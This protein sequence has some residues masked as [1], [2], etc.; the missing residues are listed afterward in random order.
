MKM[1]SRKPKAK[2][3]AS[4]KTKSETKGKE[5]THGS[6]NPKGISKAPPNPHHSHHSASHTSSTPHPPP[7]HPPSSSSRCPDHHRYHHGS[8]PPQPPPAP[9]QALN[10]SPTIAVRHPPGSSHQIGCYTAHKTSP[11]PR[12]VTETPRDSQGF[13]DAKVS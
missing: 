6:E 4:N 12:S 11:I 2:V 1:Q 13:Y 3:N 9:P 7:L 8:L 5:P 10:P